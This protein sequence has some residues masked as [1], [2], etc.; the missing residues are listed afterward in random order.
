MKRF[1]SPL[2]CLMVIACALLVVARYGVMAQSVKGKIYTVAER[3][4]EYPGG[5]AALSLFL[6]ENIQVPNS[7]VRKNYD[8]GPIA[9]KFIIDDLGYVHDIRVTTKPLDKKTLKRMQ[10]FMTAVIAAVEKMPR[11]RPGEVDGNPVA[12]FYTLPIEVNMH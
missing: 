9:A 12:V 10:G 4:P 11:W 6:A 3:Q 5:K 7:L 2:L 8:T 1:A